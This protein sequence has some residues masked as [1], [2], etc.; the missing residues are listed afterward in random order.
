MDTNE[1]L[2]MSDTQR[3]HLQNMIKQNN[4]EDQNELI[5]KLKHSELFKIEIQK[6]LDV[7]AELIGESEE[8]IY[9]ETAREA[10]FLF[11]YYT[12]LFN[13]IR[14]DEIDID[15]L[16]KFI[17]VLKKIEDGELDQHTGSFLVGSLLKK[18][19]VDSALKKSEKLD[20][21]YGV[22]TSSLLVEENKAVNI[23]YKEFKRNI[24]KTPK[25][26]KKNNK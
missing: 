19:Y 7:K 4:V 25:N 10:N 18:I 20:E 16:Y 13:K 23:S 11:T 1:I 22:S 5:R 14:K 6:M 9:E 12:D 8:K 21:K 2:D 15:L 26:V 24:L 3:L 17:D